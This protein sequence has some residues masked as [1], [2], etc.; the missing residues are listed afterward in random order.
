M[1]TVSTGP[2]KQEFVFVTVRSLERRRAALQLGSPSVRTPTQTGGVKLRG[3]AYISDLK[4]KSCQWK[5]WALEFRWTSSK[6]LW[7]RVYSQ[8]FRLNVS[9]IISLLLLFFAPHIFT[10][11]HNLNTSAAKY[12]ASLINTLLFSVK[13]LKKSCVF[14]GILDGAEVQFYQAIVASIQN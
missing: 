14:T 13:C 2:I 10:H 9:Q 12:K 4:R 7:R 3:N 11:K 8:E 1:E 6:H 5:N